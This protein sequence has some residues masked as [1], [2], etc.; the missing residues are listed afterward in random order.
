MRAWNALL[1]A[2]VIPVFALAAP[3]LADTL[4]VPADHPDIASALAVAVAGDEVVV[5]A[6][7]Y[8]E[9][10]LILPSGVV[11]RGAT[12]DPADVV[13]DGER[14]GRCVYGA[15]LDAATRIE[16][17]TLSN[18]LPALGST[19]HN[20]WGAG[21]MVD[22][23]ALTVAN[24]VFTGNETAVGG[25]AYVI[26]TGT[27]AFIDCV[28]DG[29]EASESAGLLLRGTCD[30][31][32]Q[33]CVFRNGDR[34]MVGGGLTWGGSGHALIEGCTVEDNIVLETGGGVEIIGAGAL[35]TLRDCVI[36]RNSASLGAGGLFVG[37]YGHAILELCA[38]TG[39]SSD[40]A[41]GGVILDFGAVLEAFDT[42]ILDNTAPTAPDGLVG[43]SASATLT[44][45]IIALDAW[46]DFGSLVVENDGCPIAAETATLGEVKSLF[47]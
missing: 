39:N 5:A 18:G 22:G 10:D 33:D 36:R 16:A 14:A 8:P 32:V 43:S 30:P 2:L 24:C 9:H 46:R 6:D 28:F 25:G 29:N 7:T 42:T 40:N 34:T 41:G 31:L 3:C 4:N 17:L 12:G 45:C 27:P 13:I 47:K 38:I 35:A 11:L 44:C 23:G 37:N 19:P 20:S 21:L 1:P 15:D 26:G